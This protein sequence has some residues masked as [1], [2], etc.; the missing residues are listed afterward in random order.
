MCSC[1]QTLEQTDYA[2]QAKV[3]DVSQKYVFKIAA[4]YEQIPCDQLL[5]VLD[6][7]QSLVNQDSS[8]ACYLLQDDLPTTLV[9]LCNHGDFQVQL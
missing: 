6:L 8:A 1:L 3:L 7:I 4:F 5:G 9:Q 2:Q